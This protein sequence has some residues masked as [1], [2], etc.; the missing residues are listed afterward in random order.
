MLPWNIHHN[1]LIR[2]REKEKEGERQTDNKKRVTLFSCTA[3]A[4]AAMFSSVFLHPQ[5]GI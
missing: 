1:P 2:M 5:R 4:S 3:G